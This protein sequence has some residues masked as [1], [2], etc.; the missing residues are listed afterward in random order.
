MLLAVCRIV[1]NETHTLEKAFPPWEIPV[2]TALHG[3]D[4]VT[5]LGTIEDG[6]DFPDPE[7]EY[8]RLAQRY[9][10]D[11]E[12]RD[13]IVGRVYGSIDGL[14]VSNLARAIEEGMPDDEHFERLDELSEIDVSHLEDYPDLARGVH[15]GNI[16]L[17]LAEELAEARTAQLA[18]DAA[19]IAEDPDGTA[20][21]ADKQKAKTSKKKTATKSRAKSRQRKKPVAA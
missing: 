5:V 11:S 8:Q 7:D 15:L 12:D 14:G 13:L 4:S 3:R 20:T 16:T 10:V 1:R 21:G 9:G 19:A 6:R 17:D 18:R 2:L